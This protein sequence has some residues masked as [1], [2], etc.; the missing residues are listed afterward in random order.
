MIHMLQGV[1]E[2]GTARSLKTTFGIQSQIA[3][4]TGT[5]QN[6]ADGW[7]IG[8]S[9]GL[10]AG[11]WVGADNPGIR[12]RSTLL[13]Q[14]AHT[15][16]PVFGHFFRQIERHG[17]VSD[18]GRRSF[19]PLPEGLLAKVDCPDYVEEDPD[20]NFFQRLFGGDKKEKTKKEERHDDDTKQ[21]VEEEEEEEDKGKSLLNRMKDIFRKK[22]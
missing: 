3:G 5:T 17:A 8:F 21:P 14:G 4:K 2:R 10:V 11:A 19:Y 1:V 18:I 9:P 6:N 12:F 13:G 22:D 15:A 16:L 20:L 7:F